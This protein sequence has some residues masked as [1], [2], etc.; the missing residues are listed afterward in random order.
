[1]K[2]PFRFCRKGAFS[3][4]VKTW[5]RKARRRQRRKENYQK[6]LALLAG[7]ARP[8]SA[9][10]APSVLKI[11]GV[12]FLTLFALVLASVAPLRADDLAAQVHAELNLARTAPRQ[13]AQIVASRALGHRHIEGDRVVEEAVRFLEKARPLPPFTRSEGLSASALAHVLDL[14]PSGGRGHTGSDGSTPWKRMARFGRWSGHAAEN[15]SYGE[16]DARGIV[17]ALIVDD[18]A[19]D[20]L[21]RQNIFSRDLFCVG[22]ASGPHAGCG[23]LCVMDFAEAFAEAGPRVAMGAK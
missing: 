15:I 4:G 6:I 11:P 17:V 14:G 22:V 21:H 20:R 5:E 3:S 23:T 18:G 16:R 2:T 9:S 7:L 13:Y 1:M 10:L 8:Q 19:R 12:K